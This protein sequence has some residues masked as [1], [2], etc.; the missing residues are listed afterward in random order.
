MKELCAQLRVLEW[1]NRCFLRIFRWWRNY[2]NDIPHDHVAMVADF[3]NPPK[4]GRGG[5]KETNNTP[6]ELRTVNIK[7]QNLLVLI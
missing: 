2:I 1:H 6:F 5:P 3:K 4:I 7:K